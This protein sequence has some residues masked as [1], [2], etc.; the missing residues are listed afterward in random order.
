M[1]RFGELELSQA[2]GTM[3]SRGLKVQAGTVLQHDEGSYNLTEYRMRGGNDRDVIDSRVRAEG[4]L[5]LDRR[6]ILAA[7][8]HNILLPV[9]EIK[10]PILVEVTE[11][12]GPHPAIVHHGRRGIRRH[13]RGRRTPAVAIPTWQ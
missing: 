11:I 13:R 1:Q 8:T 2:V 7:T 4:F 5:N 3:T 9:D 6:N 12:T 10:E